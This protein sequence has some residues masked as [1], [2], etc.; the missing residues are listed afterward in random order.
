VWK[1]KI[2]VIHTGA[3]KRKAVTEVSNLPK[4]SEQKPARVK[5]FP[6]PKTWAC[7]PFAGS[8]LTG[9]A[10]SLLGV[11]DFDD[12]KCH[13]PEWQ[14]LGSAE[15]KVAGFSARARD[16][17]QIGKCQTDFSDAKRKFVS[18][19]LMCINNSLAN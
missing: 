8:L 7:S 17:K 16:G 5:K 10:C 13:F 2:A 18:E 9:W 6:K 4:G 3:A 11:Q 19:L 1:R 14:Y 12:A 15:K